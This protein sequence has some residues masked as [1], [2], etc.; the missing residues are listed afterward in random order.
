MGRRANGEGHVRK[1]ADG[2]WEASVAWTDPDTGKLRRQS[3]YAPSA[4]TARDKLKAARERL[5]EGAPVKDASRTVGEWLAHWRDTTLEA[6]DRRPTTK[7]LYATLSR[8][9]LEVAPLGLVRLDRLKPSDVDGLIL[10]MRSQEKAGGRGGGGADPVRKY[11]DATIR[12]VYTILR[13]GLDGGAV[14]DGLLAKNPAAL[15]KRP[16]IARQE[17]RHLDPTTVT[18]VLRAAEESRYHPALYLIAT[19]G[20]RRGEALGLRWE[21]VDLDA[22]GSSE[23]PEP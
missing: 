10:R 7:Q 21:N 4:K 9:H 14:R 5:D 23:S 19:T 6:S 11:A 2:R 15:V 16:G 3:F 12:Q 1:R 8:K 13:A 20:L 18:A 17:A 22:G